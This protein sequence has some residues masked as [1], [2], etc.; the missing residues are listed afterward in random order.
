MVQDDRSLAVA[1]VGGSPIVARR[2]YR[3]GFRAT[4][5]ELR[6]TARNHGADPASWTH[7]V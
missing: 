1:V 4:S 6:T 3:A 5:H 2:D 7:V